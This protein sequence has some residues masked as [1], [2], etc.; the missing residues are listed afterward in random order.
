MYSFAKEDL[1]QDHPRQRRITRRKSRQKRTAIL[2]FGV[3]LV[4]VL[5][6]FWLYRAS[7]AYAIIV[8]GRQVA[9]V[10]KQADGEKAVQVYLSELSKKVGS[11]VTIED[12]VEFKQVQVD[13]KDVVFGKNI[14]K[15]LD[16]ALSPTTKGATIIVNGK[17]VL[18]LSSKTAAEDLID[19]IKNRYNSQYKNV[20]VVK[21]EV[22]EKVQVVAGKVPVKEL[23]DLH[24]A[25][26]VLTAGTE[27][28]VTHKVAAG[29]SIWSIAKNNKMSAD[30]LIAANPQ[31][32]PDK[33][34][35]GD[36]LKLTKTEPVLHV[37]S[38]VEY[39]EVKQIPFDKQVQMDKSMARGKEK[40]LQQGQDG[41]K[42]F[43]YR[44]VAVNG[45]VVD[46]QFLSATVLSKAVPKVV[47]KGTKL[48]L[49]S[50]GGSGELRWPL[51]GGI[52]S[53]FGYRGREFHTGLDIDAFIGE[54]VR[55]AEYGTVI[56][57]GWGG[58]YGNM[59]KIDHGSG[60]QTWYC[61]LSG[62]NVSVGDR[63]ERGE[64][65]GEAGSTGRSTGPH[66]HFEVRVHGNPVNPLKYLN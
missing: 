58:N 50:R 36:E 31:I 11:P 21:T 17:N 66:L 60:V 28:I 14:N 9:V 10:E 44:T 12:K 59:I 35:I 8:N 2:V 15:A 23:T 64:A 39:S 1:L 32:N 57:T 24:K 20:K 61:H 37:T 49:A 22:K 38:V 65:I 45:Q 26:Q 13:K 43:Y 25:W 19:K 16:Q 63:V 48:V 42:E 40:V 4:A 56:D 3:A 62:I 54:T 33:I 34:G 18:V 41:S 7:M 5:A 46:K 30:E 55:A 53:P 47:Q 29:E 6:A 51:R 27:K 52:N